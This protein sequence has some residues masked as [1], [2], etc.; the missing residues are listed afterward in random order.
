MIFKLCLAG[1]VFT[2][3]HV[4]YYIFPHVYCRCS[5]ARYEILYDDF[6]F[7][8]FLKFTSRFASVDSSNV[9]VMK[10]LAASYFVLMRLL[11]CFI[12]N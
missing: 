4:Q 9:A 11:C 1:A 10:Y 3:Y 8:Q 2:A 6:C 5:I 12:Q 7:P